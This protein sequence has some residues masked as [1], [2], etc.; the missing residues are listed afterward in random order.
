MWVPLTLTNSGTVLPS[1]P[2]SLFALICL[3]TH[4]R[5][6][7]SEGDDYLESLTHQNLQLLVNKLYQLPLERT[8]HGSIA[9]L[10]ASAYK[11]PRATPA[12]PPILH[13]RSLGCELA[14]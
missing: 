12:S 13:G 11:L 10:P 1:A 9:T 8:A 6:C 2:F 5:A 14:D 7:S 4:V 3:L